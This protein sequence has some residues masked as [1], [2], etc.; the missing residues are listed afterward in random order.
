MA[1]ISINLLPAE[2]LQEEGKRTKFYKIQAI[3]I[4]V[5]L[6]MVFFSSLSVALRILQS[7]S[8]KNV[9]IRVTAAEERIGQ[10]KDT[11][12]SLILLKNRLSAINEYLNKPSAQAQLYAILGK[13]IPSNVGISSIS[14]DKSGQ[15]QVLASVPDSS[16]LDNL[17]SSLVNTETNGGKIEEV[18]MDTVSR[19]KDGDYRINFRLKTSTK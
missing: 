13:I 16:T 2:F 7:Q 18:S 3:G 6:L 11:Q 10:L 17:I 9:Q 5:I 14:I 4:F 19:G 8:V 1:K 12:A 15:A